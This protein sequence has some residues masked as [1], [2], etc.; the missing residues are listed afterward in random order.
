MNRDGQLIL[1]SNDVTL[2]IKAMAEVPYLLLTL[3]F[4]LRI[5]TLENENV[6]VSGI[7]L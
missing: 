4:C 1:L 6:F 5:L 3:S 7:D 2:K